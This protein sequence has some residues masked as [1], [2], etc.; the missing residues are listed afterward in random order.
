M[1]G[2][3]DDTDDVDSLIINMVFQL[4]L[5]LLLYSKDEQNN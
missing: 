5:L 4:L 3:T 2:W 1:I